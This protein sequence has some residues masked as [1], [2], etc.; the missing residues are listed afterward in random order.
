MAANSTGKQYSGFFHSQYLSPTIYHFYE[1]FLRSEFTSHKSSV[2]SLAVLC[3]A[4]PLLQDSLTVLTMYYLSWLI[5]A[6]LASS[7]L[8]KHCEN[9]FVPVS[10]SARNGIFNVPP[11]HY[12]HDATIFFANVTNPAGNFSDEVLLGYR[13]IKNTYDISVKFCRPNASYRRGSTLQ[14]L[15]HGI[16][17]DKT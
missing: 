14:F 5:C 11:L 6:L 8:A 4:R 2:A 1:S 3:V 15:T 10:L 13:T 16:G 17:F 7:V 9:F 12:N